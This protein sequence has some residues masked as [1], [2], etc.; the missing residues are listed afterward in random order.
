MQELNSLFR[1]NNESLV[2][3]PLS[4]TNQ[5]RETVFCLRCGAYRW[6]LKSVRWPLMASAICDNLCRVGRPD[7]MIHRVDRHIQALTGVS[8][9]LSLTAWTAGHEGCHLAWSAESSPWR[10]MQIHFKQYCEKF[11]CRARLNSF[12]NVINS[13]FPHDKQLTR[14]ISAFWGMQV[15]FDEHF[16]QCQSS[17]RVSR[18]SLSDMLGQLARNRESP[19]ELSLSFLSVLQEFKMW[20]IVP[21]SWIHSTT[22]TKSPGR[23]VSAITFALCHFAPL[24]K[25]FHASDLLIA[26]LASS[27]WCR[28]FFIEQTIP[29]FELLIQMS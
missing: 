20:P 13:I 12:S 2:V 15:N 18:D 16:D 25:C 17:I 23:I 21:R 14:N 4:E 5:W 24:F 28:V 27:D 9:S 10:G 6:I 26:L 19:C 29:L 8:E 22:D 7:G 1:E 11:R 3:H